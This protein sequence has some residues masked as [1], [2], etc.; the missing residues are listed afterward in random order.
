MKR[1]R[2]EERDLH[3][4]GRNDHCDTGSNRV[5]VIGRAGQYVQVA[6]SSEWVEGH[7]PSRAKSVKVILIDSLFQMQYG[8]VYGGG[9]A[10]YISP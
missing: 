6:R 10:L 2:D 3:C 9:M 8:H 5:H 7:L 4:C 1:L